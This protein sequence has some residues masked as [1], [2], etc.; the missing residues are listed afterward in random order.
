MM[1][2]QNEKKLSAFT[3]IISTFIKS[4]IEFLGDLRHAPAGFGARDIRRNVGDGISVLAKQCVA[5]RE[6]HIVMAADAFVLGAALVISVRRKQSLVEVTNTGRA[7]VFGDDVLEV[8]R[9][10][11][12]QHAAA[13]LDDSGDGQRIPKRFAKAM[14]EKKFLL[15]D[16]RIRPTLQEARRGIDDRRAAFLEFRLPGFD[17][18]PAIERPRR[19][20]FAA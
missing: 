17:S 6:P 4:R 12:R 2:W 3:S 5:H 18:G 14:T 1:P 9:D 8:R 20:I 7:C 15:L 16:G 11:L 10:G 19:N 13:R